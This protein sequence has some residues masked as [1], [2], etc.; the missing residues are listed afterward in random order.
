MSTQSS[1][2]ILNLVLLVVILG[3]VAIVVYEPGKEKPLTPP[4]LTQLKAADINNIKISRQTDKRDIELSKTA[5]G[6]VILKPFQ[7]PANTF[8]IDSIL[9]LLS[10]V[11]FS[12]N[13]LDKLDPRN[14]GLDKPFATITLNNKTLIIFGHNKSL[15]HLRYVQIGSVL[16]M[17]ADTF[18]YQ[19][20]AKA[21]SFIDHQL[22]PK[23]RKITQLHLPGLKL[24]QKEDKWDVTP[25]PRH[26]S[27]DSVNELISEWQLS[28]AY[29]I[30]YDKNKIEPRADAHADIRITLDNQDVMRFN[31][32]KDPDGFA[33]LNVNNGVKYIL[34]QDRKNKLL[35]LPEPESSDKQ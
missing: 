30:G 25:K 33:L 32:V 4:T 22:I 10:T 8:R 34:T 2:N 20:A 13:D 11:S 1:R 6:W 29:D 19:L 14:F 7:L 5:N 16:H 23:A 26:F 12:Q 27:M 24:E 31:I 15:K 35:K 9:K 3:L 18:Y 21:E 17:I 28:Q